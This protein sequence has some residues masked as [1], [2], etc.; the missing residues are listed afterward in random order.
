MFNIL[1]AVGCICCYYCYYWYMYELPPNSWGPPPWEEHCPLL[2]FWCAGLRQRARRPE[3]GAFFFALSSIRVHVCRLHVCRLHILNALSL[4]SVCALRHWIIH[5][6][7][8]HVHGS[9]TL[10]ILNIVASIFRGEKSFRFLVIGR[11]QNRCGDAFFF[12]LFCRQG[13]TCDTW[14]CTVYA[15]WLY[16]CTC[17]SS[18]KASQKLV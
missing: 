11:L 5:T 9:V 18:S 12:F 15:P 17:S 2:I 14:T 7:G 6:T 10:C 3:T 13:N 16:Y 1:F 8:W 4:S